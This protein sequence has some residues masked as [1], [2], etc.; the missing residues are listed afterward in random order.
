MIVQNKYAVDVLSDD[1]DA[2]DSFLQQIE[3][4]NVVLDSLTKHSLMCRGRAL[5]KTL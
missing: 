1:N 5:E 2:R 3:R 4:M